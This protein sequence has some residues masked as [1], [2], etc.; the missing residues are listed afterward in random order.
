MATPFTEWGLARCHTHLLHPTLGKWGWL[1]PFHRCENW[2]LG[3]LN[4]FPKFTQ[5]HSGRDWIWAQLQL[6][7]QY[8]FPSSVSS[9]VKG[10]KWPL[11]GPFQGYLHVS[12]ESWD[13][14]FNPKGWLS[15]S[16]ISDFVG[17]E[18]LPQGHFNHSINC[19]LPIELLSV[20]SSAGSGD[21]WRLSSLNSLSSGAYKSRRGS[22]A[23]Y[24]SHRWRNRGPENHLWL[25]VRGG[26][27]C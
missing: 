4:T 26:S 1:Y 19:S 2:G 5:L 3:Q 23:H 25:L 13:P 27:A 7:G 24:S 9:N 20:T 11:F 16:G 14:I 17:A 22:V 8:L 12:G 15:T 21:C 6:Q 18:I 10:Q